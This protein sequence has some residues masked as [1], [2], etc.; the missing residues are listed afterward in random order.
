[1][2]QFVSNRSVHFRSIGNRLAMLCVTVLFAA[3]PADAG[4]FTPDC[5]KCTLWCSCKPKDSGASES[6]DSEP[7]SQA[8]QPPTQPI[9]QP[10][11]QQV[12]SGWGFRHVAGAAVVGGVLGPAVVVPAATKAVVYYGLYKYVQLVLEGCVIIGKAAVRRVKS[13]GAEIEDELDYSFGSKTIFKPGQTVFS[14]IERQGRGNSNERVKVGMRGKVLSA[15]SRT[16]V[17]KFEEVNPLGGECFI[18]A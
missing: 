8:A 16:V 17:V 15:D 10:T 7:S 6:G 3:S 12:G 5:G 18:Q 13:L 9:Q 1:M 11:Q 14:T 4:W 2:Y